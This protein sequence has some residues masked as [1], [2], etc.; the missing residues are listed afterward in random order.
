MEKK[1]TVCIIET[2]KG[3]KF[4]GYTETLM[5]FP[6]CQDLKDPNAFV[7][8]IDKMKI[9]ENLQKDQNAVCHYQN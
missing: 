2:K 5:D 4:G 9:Y 8:S 6:K 7:F 3:F 1:N